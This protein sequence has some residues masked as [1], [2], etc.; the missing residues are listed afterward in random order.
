MKR[1]FSHLWRVAVLRFALDAGFLLVLLGASGAVAAEEGVIG[2]DTVT[3]A[4][5][6]LTLH[7]LLWRPEV[8]GKVP[9]V[10]FNHGSGPTT[11]PDKPAA[12]GPLFARHGY[13]FLYLYRRGS[14]LSADQGTSAGELMDRELA[15]HGED[16]RDRLQLELLDQ[17][18]TDALAGLAFLRNRPD[19]DADRVAVVGHSFGGMLALLMA[20]R[21]T[22][23]RAA[24]DFAGAANSWASSQELRQRLMTAAEKT[25]APV[26][27]IHAENDYSIAP[28]EVLATVMLGLDKPRR[29]EIYPAV[30]RTTDEGHDFVYLGVSAWESDV[31]AFLDEYTRK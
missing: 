23:L 25:T 29:I 14:D 3:V 31:F 12:L 22:R 10:L 4:N 21:D 15:A 20:E 5:G 6:K 13:V 8:D 1:L 24:V 2:P 30:G 7:A 16:A 28:G 27:F 26:F 9:A 17:H 11:E 19:V 18:L